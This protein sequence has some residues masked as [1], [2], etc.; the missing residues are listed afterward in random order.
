MATPDS[1]CPTCSRPVLLAAPG[2]RRYTEGAH[3]KCREAP[4]SVNAWPGGNRHL[5]CLGCARPFESASKAQRLCRSCRS[6]GAK[7]R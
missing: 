5:L 7:P 3:L 4:G 1:M 2:A 6:D